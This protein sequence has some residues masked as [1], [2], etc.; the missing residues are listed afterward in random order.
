MIRKLNYK[1]ESDFSVTYKLNKV[2][3]IFNWYPYTE[4]FSKP[5]VDK[6]ISIFNIKKGDL[7]LDPFGGCGTTALACCLQGINSLSIEVNPF[8]NLVVKAKTQTLELNPKLLRK[9]FNLIKEKLEDKK[10]IKKIPSF[11]EGKPFFNNHNLIKA[12][13]IKESILELDLPQKHRNFFLMQLSSILV[14]ISD[15]VRATD[16]RYKKIKPGKLDIRDIF[17]DKIENGLNDL[18]NIDSKKSG[19]STILSA[20]FCNLNSNADGFYGKIDYFITSPPYLNGTNYDRNT[21]LEMGFLDIIKTDD[22]LS[23]LRKKMVTA[24]INSTKTLNKYS[25]SL[26]FIK[27]LIKKVKEKAY[28]NRIPIMVEGYFNDMNLA[29]ENLYRLLKKGGQGVMV[30]GDSQFGGVHIETDIILAK[31]CELNKLHVKSIDVVRKRTSNNGMRLRESLI[32]VKK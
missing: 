12:L 19:K 30:I 28:D 13:K 7:V 29:I 17:L 27:P 6:M 3:G 5:F 10:N 21:K 23:N 15:M 11:L 8:M 25:R 32:F 1:T 14:K 18:E 24:G 22:D 4:G 16:L 31:I 26:D 9:Q 20:D 2:N